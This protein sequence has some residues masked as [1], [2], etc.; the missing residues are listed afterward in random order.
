MVESFNSNVRY[1]AK[2][3]T[4]IE[5]RSQ[6][7]LSISIFESLKSWLAVG[8]VLE[9]CYVITITNLPNKI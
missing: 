6:E 2:K 1:L 5:I 8:K 7:T 3:R 4:E 9:N